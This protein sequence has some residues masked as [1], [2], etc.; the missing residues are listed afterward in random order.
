M[1]PIPTAVVA[2]ALIVLGKWSRGQTLNVDNVIGVVGIAVSLAV[3]EQLDER[4][5]AA[6]AVLILASLASVHLPVI[7]K[8]L[9]F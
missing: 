6:F 3:L 5:G 8:A 7:V 2:G 9:G 4:I 1:K